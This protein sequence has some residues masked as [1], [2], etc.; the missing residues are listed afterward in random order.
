MSFNTYVNGVYFNKYPYSGYLF[1]LEISTCITEENTLPASILQI[2]EF[3][4][5]KLYFCWID[6]HPDS[7]TI[8]TYKSSVRAL[9]MQ[10]LSGVTHPVL[11]S[12]G[13]HMTLCGVYGAVFPFLKPMTWQIEPHAKT[14]IHI[15]WMKFLLPLSRYMCR[16]SGVI[17]WD[18]VLKKISAVYCGSRPS[19]NTIAT[20]SIEIELNH[21]P[22][23]VIGNYGFFASYSYQDTYELYKTNIQTRGSCISN[24]RCVS[25]VTHFRSG[26]VPLMTVSWHIKA[27]LPF[28]IITITFTTAIAL[29]NQTNITFYDGPGSLSQFSTVRS[30]SDNLLHILM[31]KST[32][33]QMFVISSHPL[34]LALKNHQPVIKCTYKDEDLVKSESP[35]TF[36][37]TYKREQPT[38]DSFMTHLT[39]NSRKNYNH[40]YRWTIYLDNFHAINF[41]LH[42][43]TL[44]LV[45]VPEYYAA[46]EFVNFA[47]S[48]LCLYGG[49]YIYEF[50][51]KDAVKI[52]H[53]ALKRQLSSLNFNYIIP[54][55]Q[56]C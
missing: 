14:L 25:L 27:A 53:C 17:L 44:S 48:I 31:S 32:T 3:L 13:Y 26:W 33:F 19:W 35:A 1:Q 18:T 43:F 45:K 42:H 24:W 52:V 11:P 20:S 39:M 23:E 55:L 40:I 56:H 21:Q 34:N 4:I 8:F 37:S 36:Y 30:Q 50:T 41:A 54:R 47:D 12:H 7:D 38:D 5:D 15:K 29:S 22:I 6:Y 49:L 16:Y 46:D 9:V 28:K 10:A 2:H 51:K